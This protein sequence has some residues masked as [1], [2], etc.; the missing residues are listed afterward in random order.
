ME[1]VQKK[2][3]HHSSEHTLSLECIA[4]FKN[5]YER[6]GAGCIIPVPNELARKR[7]DIVIKEGCSDLIILLPSK[8]LFVELKI[9]YNSQQE[10]QIN[11]ESLVNNLGF[12]YYVVKSVE[13]FK[14]IL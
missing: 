11:F 6:F 2:K 5:E 10:N 7:K 8:V 4:W 3:S 13:Q 14:S 9:G 12:E 1:Q